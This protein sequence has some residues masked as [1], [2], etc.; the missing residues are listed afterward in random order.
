MANALYD[1]FVNNQFTDSTKFIDLDDAATVIKAAL[2][3]VASG[4]AFSAAHDFF[5]DLGA[6]IVGTPVALA[7]K[8]FSGRVFDAADV[9]FTAVS[10]AAVGAVVLYKETGGAGSPT[11]D[12]LIAYIDTATGLS[13][14]PNGGDITI[15]WDNGTNKIFKIV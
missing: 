13:V 11:D 1:S 9:T 7:S 8:T 4:Y 10:G 2:V 14:T 6:N 3:K 12:A 15:A 5:D